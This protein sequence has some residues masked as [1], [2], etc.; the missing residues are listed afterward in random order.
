MFFSLTSRWGEKM[1]DV[2]IKAILNNTQYQEYIRKNQD[3]EQ[4]RKYCKHGWEHSFDVA[5]VAYILA[6][7]AGRD[8]IAVLNKE[9]VYAAALLHD[10]GRWKQYDNGVDHARVGA[11]LAGKI[12]REAGFNEEEIHTV[13]EAIRCHRRPEQAACILGTILYRADK[14]VR[15]CR[16]CTARDDCNKFSEME[17]IQEGRVY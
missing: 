12:L 7:E 14:T 17:I 11:E 6:L 2:R 4:Q 16:Q 10:I 5:R 15:L 1:N 9:L 8:Q 13:R 3:R